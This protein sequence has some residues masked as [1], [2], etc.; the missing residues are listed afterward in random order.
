MAIA[1]NG[2]NEIQRACPMEGEGVMVTSWS[3]HGHPRH[4]KEALVVLVV[5]HLVVLVDPADPADL[6]ALG[7]RPRSVNHEAKSPRQLW[8]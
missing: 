6:V 3:R 2:N 1:P 7:R 5:L 4:P 8:K